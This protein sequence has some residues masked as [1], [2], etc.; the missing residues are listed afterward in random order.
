MASEELEVAAK[1]LAEVTGKELEKCRAILIAASQRPEFQST[2][3]LLKLPS[4]KIFTFL[5]RLRHESISSY[6]W[7]LNGCRPKQ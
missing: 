2:D 6:N 5:G 1:L 4:A 7:F 3:I